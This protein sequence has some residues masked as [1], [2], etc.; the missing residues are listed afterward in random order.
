M[1]PAG[2]DELFG[3][4]TTP[5]SWYVE[6]GYP[7]ITV[8]TL[9]Q[10]QPAGGKYKLGQTDD[11]RGQISYRPDLAYVSGYPTDTP[12]YSYENPNPENY[13][14]WGLFASYT[15]AAYVHKWK[16]PAKNFAPAQD[17]CGPW[18]VDTYDTR[19]S[20]PFGNFYE[21]INWT[22]FY[23]Y[24]YVAEYDQ[25]QYTVTFNAGDGEF[26]PH[27][28]EYLDEFSMYS[29]TSLIGTTRFVLPA[30]DVVGPGDMENT[31]VLT[32][33]K[34][35]DGRTYGLGE[36]YNVMK[37]LFF[38]AVYTPVPNVYTF[39]VYPVG[40][41]FPDGDK[42]KTFT[43]GYGELTGIGADPD[44]SLFDSWKTSAGVGYDYVFDGWYSTDKLTA[45]PETFGE[46]DEGVRDIVIVAKTKRVTQQHTITFNAN[47]GQFP[48]GGV[49]YTKNYAHGATINP[50]E[51]PVPT[52]GSDSWY[53]YT[54]AGWGSLETVTRDDS[55]YAVWV[56]TLVGAPMP[57]GILISDGVTT[58]DINC[59]NIS[60]GYTP[61]EG[62][63]YELVEFNDY[64]W[65]TNTTTTY[66][67][68]TLTV[69]GDGL[70]V[71]GSVS[72][73]SID[74]ED[75]VALIIE[76]GVTDIT[77][78]DLSL[79]DLFKFG[80][81]V[82][83]GEGE[84]LKITIS[85]DCH[86]EKHSVE[87]SGSYRSAFCSYRDVLFSGSDAD[88]TL[89]IT[90]ENACGISAYG[91]T[92]FENL[93]LTMT[94]SGVID[95]F[96]YGTAMATAFGSESAF[97][98]DFIN[99]DVVVSSPGSRIEG[100]VIIEGSGNFKYI[101]T[102][103]NPSLDIGRSLTFED[104][105]GTFYASVL[106]ED[107]WPAVLAE[108]GITFTVDGSPADPADYGVIVAEIDGYYTFTDEAGNYLVDVTVHRQ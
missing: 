52:R 18:W 2:Y 53:T 80:D 31:Y 101:S 35:Q 91:D 66:R 21:D 89:E 100:S 27:M 82:C 85:G 68:P 7:A 104:F 16:R 107:A 65:S 81:L 49:S 97:M 93:K 102:D 50:E 34:D 64:D 11:G 48:E 37:D 15:A 41:A 67:I 57:T 22:R 4:W 32:G 36:R 99:S 105:E 30:D 43:G 84:P 46:L 44:F 98:I 87:K 17:V 40:A 92:A 47:G 71:S 61:I 20:D 14:D 88:A 12:L 62:Y 56:M 6:T 86:L 45:W 58:E 38:T 3:G 79:T 1:L 90:A 39:T 25:K 108:E 13:T 94:V 26:A 75:M 76:E 8:T 74:I 95:E 63:K 83:V 9:D 70:T 55:C 24:L 5:V 60:E 19:V 73:G 28:V 69:T 10:L 33:W 51:I 77:F 96:D 54:F 103:D 23:E 29:F 106:G 72:G 42:K 59:V 78:K